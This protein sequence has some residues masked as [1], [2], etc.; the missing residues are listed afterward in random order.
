VASWQLCPPSDAPT[1]H[2]A[3][4]APSPWERGPLGDPRV[5][6]KG[7]DAYYDECIR[8]RSLGWGRRYLLAGTGK[9]IGDLETSRATAHE[10]VR[11]PG[12][13]YLTLSPDDDPARGARAE[14]RSHLLVDGSHYLVIGVP[15]APK[16]AKT[17]D[18]QIVRV[19]AGGVAAIDDAEHRQVARR[20]IDA[21]E[22]DRPHR[23]FKPLWLDVDPGLD[24]ALAMLIEGRPERDTIPPPPSG[25][26]TIVPS[27]ATALLCS[28]CGHACPPEHAYCGHCGRPLKQS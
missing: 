14:V 16:V 5:V 17:G 1:E 7:S 13:V 22:N 6:E 8:E 26:P 25:N 4:A 24:D 27:P 9:E 28:E 15:D 3:E 11:S 18:L 2:P 19:C 12:R 21:L 10:V 23:R 20:L